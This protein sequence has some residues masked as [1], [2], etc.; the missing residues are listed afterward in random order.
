MRAETK[1]A[2]TKYLRIEHQSVSQEKQRNFTGADYSHV[3]EFLYSRAVQNPSAT[4][5]EGL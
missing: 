4:M 5:G 3:K 1:S 2:M